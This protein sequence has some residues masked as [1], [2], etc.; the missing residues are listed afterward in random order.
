VTDSNRAMTNSPVGTGDALTD[1]LATAQTLFDGSVSER[2]QLQPNPAQ[3]SPGQLAFGVVPNARSPRLLVPLVPKRAA[4]NALRRFSTATPLREA[5]FRVLVSNAVGLMPSRI[6]RD[7]IS[8]ESGRAGLAGHLSEVL[9]DRVTLSLGIGNARVNRKPVLQVFDR[10]GNTVA[11][12]KI[13]DSDLGRE[14]VAAEGRALRQLGARQWIHLRIPQLM[15]ETDW[16]GMRVLLMSA[17]EVPPIQRPRDRWEPPLAAMSELSDAF[18]AGSLRL[19]ESPWIDRQRQLGSKV[20]DES[21]RRR[22]A[23][24][25]D[26]VCRWSGQDLLPF[27]CWHGDWTAWNMGRARGKILLWDWERFETAVPSGLDP[28]HY[29]VNSVTVRSGSSADAFRRGIA[30]SLGGA[31][32][33]GSPEHLRACLYLIAVTARYLGLIETPR[34]TTIARRA[35]DGLLALESE[36]ETVRRPC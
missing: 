33:P 6:L 8:I 21:V 26:F 1:L 22:F 34:G 32:R 15:S 30:L 18:S 7:Q 5:A 24:C 3:S 17:L 36:I 20:R 10:C 23:S 9:G 13:G 25:V 31:P 16:R 29:R 28:L 19:H 14:D 4:G 27:S 11:F 35:A 2:A 12:A